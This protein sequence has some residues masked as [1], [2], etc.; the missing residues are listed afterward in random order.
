MHRTPVRPY[1]EQGSPITTSRSGLNPT[2]ECRWERIRSGFHNILVGV[3]LTKSKPL[4]VVAIDSVAENAVGRALWVARG[5][6]S[7][8]TFV[9]ALPHRGKRNRSGT[10]LRRLLTT[11]SRVRGRWKRPSGT[12]WL[13]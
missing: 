11:N 4:G 10:F 9:S 6:G 7:P 13:A 2:R 3:D 5:G 1:R 12:P 8:L